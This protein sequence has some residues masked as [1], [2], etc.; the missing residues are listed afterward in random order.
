MKT[1]CFVNVRNAEL[2]QILISIKWC[3]VMNQLLFMDS[4]DTHSTTMAGRILNAVRNEFRGCVFKNAS[5]VQNI[6]Y[7]FWEFSVLFISNATQ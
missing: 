3:A 7:E 2:E 4:K 5:Q 1:I 6:C